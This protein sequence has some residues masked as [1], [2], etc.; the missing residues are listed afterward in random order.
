[1][2]QADTLVLNHPPVSLTANASKILTDSPKAAL[3]ICIIN[4][5]I[6]YNA[7]VDYAL[8]GNLPKSII[9]ETGQTIPTRSLIYGNG[10]DLTINNTSSNPNALIKVAIFGLG[11]ATKGQIEANQKPTSLAQFDSTLV[12]TNPEWMTYRVVATTNMETLVY[13]FYEDSMPKVIV[14]NYTGSGFDNCT[15]TTTSQYKEMGNWQGNPLFFINA[16]DKE[17]CLFTVEIETYC[18]LNP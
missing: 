4:S 10:C 17:N 2:T 16:S 5:N 14:L 15:T 9:V 3:L 6:E 8:G 13:V 18:Y 1:M 7:T 12:D 11:Q